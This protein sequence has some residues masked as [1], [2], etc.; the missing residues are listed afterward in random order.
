MK[1][2]VIKGDEIICG[3]KTFLRDKNAKVVNTEDIILSFN[4][5]HEK[6]PNGIRAKAFEI[7][8]KLMGE[9]RICF[10]GAKPIIDAEVW[11]YQKRR[12]GKMQIELEVGIYQESG[13]EVSWGV[14]IKKGSELYEPLRKYVMELLDRVMFGTKEEE[15]K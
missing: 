1:R 2:W 11:I 6:M 15:N 3:T 5:F 9:N 13:K 4:A 8:E 10:S 12:N 7:A 14:E